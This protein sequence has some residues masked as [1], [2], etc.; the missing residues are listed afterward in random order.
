MGLSSLKDKYFI[1]SPF[2]FKIKIKMLNKRL[3]I[4]CQDYYGRFQKV[5]IDTSLDYLRKL[6]DKQTPRAKK[7]YLRL[8]KPRTCSLSTYVTS[9]VIDVLQ[10]QFILKTL[11]KVNLNSSSQDPYDQAL[12][13]FF[14]HL[15]RELMPYLRKEIF[16]APFH[17]RQKIWQSFNLSIKEIED[18]F[19]NLVEAGKNEIQTRNYSSFFD[20][21]LE[22]NKI[23]QNDYLQFI[24]NADQLIVSLNHQLP[25]IKNFPSWFYS[26]FNLPCF[27]CQ[28]DSFPFHSL[29]ETFSF[30]VRQYPILEKFQSKI[31]IKIE[32][33][34]TFAIYD[35]KRD[36][37]KIKIKEGLN[38]RHQ[39]VLLIHELGHAISLLN[40][41][42]EGRDLLF[43]IGK[44]GAEKEAIKIEVDVLKKASPLL[45]RASLGEV[46]LFPFRNTLFEIELHQSPKKNPSKLYARSF[47]RCFLEAKQKD[48]PLY[49]L[50]E[51]FIASPF[52]QLPH[53]IARYH[54]LSSLKSEDT[55]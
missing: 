8:S 25:K 47:N 3:E 52:F 19:Q 55:I 51:H 16:N 10:R 9:W 53:A 45:Y 6:A 30:V 5:K 50:E 46:L 35:I 36:V 33:K 27:I 43:A 14:Y 32:G 37:I 15:P 18:K 1:F 42:H 49:L 2:F 23:P 31:E 28:L 54:V 13:S 44:Y 38:I 17:Q 29:K 20:V 22:K 4:V 48:N 11:R 34:N 12:T 7:N 39:A 41:L 24:N 40:N 26:E 21:L